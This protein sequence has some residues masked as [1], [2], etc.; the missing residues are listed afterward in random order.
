MAKV[1]IKTRCSRSGA[2][3]ICAACVVV[4]LLVRPA[5]TDETEVSWRVVPGGQIVNASGDAFGNAY[6]LGQSG[7]T[8]TKYDVL[9]NSLWTHRLSADQLNVATCLA[10]TGGGDCYVA[11]RTMGTTTLVG[12]DSQTITGNHAFVAR[13][14][15]DGTLIWARLIGSTGNDVANRIVVDADDNCYVVGDTSGCIDGQDLPAA[16]TDPFAARL[17]GA[18]DLIWISQLREASTSRGRGIGADGD[19]R[20][21]IAGEP[22]FV[23]TYDAEGSLLQCHR[24]SHTI[25]FMQDVAADGLGN[26]YFCGWD[27]PYNAIVTKFDRD[28]VFVWDQRFRLNGW[29]CP[30]SIAVCPDGS[31]DIVTGGCEG[32]F[33]AGRGCQA[34]SRRFDPEGNLVSICTVDDVCG[35]A[36]GVDGMGNWYV[37]GDAIVAKAGAPVYSL[38]P[39]AFEAEAATFTGATVEVAQVDC[40]GDA[41][42]GFA[43]GEEGSVE[44]T[45]GVARAGTKTLLWRFLNCTGHTLPASLH[46]NG[47]AVAPE[48]TFTGTTE[49]DWTSLT[50]EAYLCMGRNTVALTLTAP[51]EL[52]LYL[53]KLEIIDAEDN[54]AQD[55]AVTCSSDSEAGPAAGAVDG[56][57]A[58][59]WSVSEGSQWIEIDLG[60][61][62]P[63]SQ[64]MLTGRSDGPCAFAVEMKLTAA[65]AYQ[66]VVDCL[67]DAE[68]LV[69]IHPVVN[70]FSRTLARFVRLTIAGHVDGGTVDVQEFGVF[71][72]AEHGAITDGTRDYRTIQEAIDR[73]ATGATVT[74]QPGWYAGP[75]NGNLQWRRNAITLASLDANDP[76][77]V[78]GTVIEGTAAAPVVTLLD[79]D[80]DSQLAGLTITG[81]LAG[82]YCQDA[83][84]QIENCRIIEN[85]GP[86]IEI[87]VK[88]DP[89]IRRTIV[90][91]NAGPGVL[92]VPRMGGRRPTYNEPSF[93]NCTIAHNAAE[94]AAGGQFTM[95]N[96][97]VWAN[98]ADAGTVQLAPAEAVVSYSCVQGGFPGEGNIAADPTFLAV[99]D[100]HLASGSPCI[101][102]GDSGDPVGAE[103]APHG[104]RINLG[105]YGGTAQA[106]RTALGN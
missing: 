73:A 61:P 15:G 46:V 22:G 30:K 66:Q 1:S 99:D 92:M 39:S 72:T 23:A 16:G 95:R 63:I 36:V 38:A 29:S 68:E 20:V 97:I 77:V 52:G 48:L 26:A 28:G 90:A 69:P 43:Q 32:S 11:G 56:R 33:T 10:G 55:R 14:A 44:W 18:G 41:Y 84:P 9:G 70:S 17:S 2:V 59:C 34:F 7:A 82:L 98:G 76:D 94:G 31:N 89:I 74:L 96:C 50:T 25:P 65:D 53:D 13:Y 62:Y 78:A 88:S 105:A 100:Y 6:A 45:A 51:A 24:F 4:L 87:Q 57:L 49:D 5:L 67:D 104:D 102:A 37:I 75:G 42:L 54:V 64:I 101:D 83:S 60:Q 79:L 71:V 85:Q 12:D 106:T 103:P 35:Q 58:S 19:G 47:V 21:T 81:G 40:S 86:G 8:L 91:A 80:A 27:S 3:L 93:I